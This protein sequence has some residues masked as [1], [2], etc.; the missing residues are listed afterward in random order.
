MIELG[1]LKPCS[2]GAKGLQ[3]NANG[4]RRLLEMGRALGWPSPLVLRQAVLF[5]HLARLALTLK[6]VSEVEVQFLRSSSELAFTLQY[7][8]GPIEAH[9]LPACDRSEQI[10]LDDGRQ[11]L[12]LLVGEPDDLLSIL[13][14]ERLEQARQCLAIRS[15]DELFADVQVKNQALEEAHQTLEQRINE[16]TME[17]QQAMA[18]AEA[19][20]ETKSAFLANMSH[21]IRT[22]M[23]AIIG[24]A[25][26]CLKTDLNARQ[27][28][29]VTKIHH[30]GQSLLGILND[31]LDFSRIEAG[32]L[33][34]EAI[35]FE[36][37]TVLES[38]VTVIAQRAYSKGLEL[39]IE[40]REDV[41]PHLIGDPLRLGQ[42]LTNLVGNAIKFTEQGQVGLEISLVQAQGQELQLR[43]VVEDTGIGMSPEQCRK[44]FKAFSQADESTTRKY[45]G[46]GLGLAISKRLVEMMGGEIDVSSEQDKGSRFFF[47]ANFG[48]GEGR[49]TRPVLPPQLHRARALIVDDN[50]V[51]ERILRKLLERLELRVDSCQSALAS[52]DLLAAADGLDPYRLV[53]LDWKMPVVDGMQAAQHIRHELPLSHPPRLIMVTAFGMEETRAKAEAIGVD[54]FL[55]K[56][57]N[58]SSLL[59]ALMDLYG[60]YKLKLPAPDASEPS[61][62]F[63]D[64]HV[65]LVED[66]EINRQ[67]ALELF[68]LVGVSA[69]V[70]VNGQEAVEHLLRSGPEPFDIVFMDMQMPVMDGHE[71]AKR[72]RADPQFDSLPIIAMT[73]HAMAEERERC[74]SEGMQAHISKPLDPGNLYRHIAQYSGKELKAQHAEG[75]P[76]EAAALSETAA[77]Q[78][79][80]ERLSK[81]I[82]QPSPEGEAL[83]AALPGLD[84]A[85]ALQRFVNDAG[86]LR[87][88]LQRFCVNQRQALE[89][90]SSALKRQNWAEGERV[91]HT[92]KGL[93][94][95]FGMD[96]LAQAA[97]ALE[98]ALRQPEPEAQVLH[99]GMAELS[100]ALQSVLGQLDAYF[101]KASD[102]TVEIYEPAPSAHAAPGD[103]AAVQALQE[104]LR[105]LLQASDLDALALAEESSDLLRSW[106]GSS[107]ADALMDHLQLFDFDAALAL[108]DAAKG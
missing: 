49:P 64:V 81:F 18:I 50:P 80:Q 91:A 48:R 78:D 60:D 45:G 79:M 89:E 74:L 27:H 63:E 104:R 61:L 34:M 94:A 35:E 82:T 90:L 88:T 67:I 70:A 5:S 108:L 42:I 73:A 16:R 14:A 6:E 15:A 87:N 4:R 11:Q 3:P 40:V 58:P 33:A 21:E 32:K 23:N 66:N 7:Q 84:I 43:F 29:Y 25:H 83:I 12:R 97:G 57:V 37:S 107:Q 51:A 30:S 2:R 98:Q 65:L 68:A 20:V 96:A 99:S 93:S 39:L 100:Q 106:L 24:L 103:P 28:D 55:H 54:G 47:T 13:D 10:R 19:A 53:F 102:A 92:L 46:T 9:E 101:G 8:G 31:I 69:E 62:R 72:L 56:P 71:A 85:A 75:G 44:M 1:R 17:L 22:P 105:Q 38:L 52:Y 41:P 76:V 95:T 77:A 86:S 59:D 26:L 36:L